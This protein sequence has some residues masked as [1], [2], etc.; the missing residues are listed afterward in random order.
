MLQPGNS[1]SPGMKQSLRSQKKKFNSVCVDR[2]RRWGTMFL[3]SPHNHESGDRSTEARI[4]VSY[5]K[6]RRRRGGVS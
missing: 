2:E 1:G 6:I 4:S 5:P 3:R